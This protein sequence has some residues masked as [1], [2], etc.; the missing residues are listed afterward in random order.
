MTTP[1]NPNT[2]LI[3]G[4]LDDGE[5]LPSSVVLDGILLTAA[6]VTPPAAIAFDSTGWSTNGISTIGGRQSQG[7]NA[8]KAELVA[9]G[10]V[11]ATVSKVIPTWHQGRFWAPPVAYGFATRDNRYATPANPSPLSPVQVQQ[12]IMAMVQMQNSKEF[13]EAIQG[14]DLKDL[15][16]GVVGTKLTANTSAA[17]QYDPNAKTWAQ[18]GETY[19]DVIEL[20]VLGAFRGAFYLGYGQVDTTQPFP[21]HN[22]YDPFFNVQN[23]GDPTRFWRAAA[24]GMGATIPA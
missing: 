1:V 23:D 14:F 10:G 22:V 18:N 9:A 11:N 20:N 24:I 21:D 8:L 2:A 12:I 3:Q 6:I 4:L 5:L 13:I 17:I 15:F 16:R 19:Y 7:V